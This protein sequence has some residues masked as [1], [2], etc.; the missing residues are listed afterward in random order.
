MSTLLLRLMGPMQS[1][2]TQYGFLVRLTD[3][4]PSFSGVVGLIA[5]AMGRSEREPIDDL[6]SGLQMGVRV[7][8]PG[9]LGVDFQTVMGGK[10]GRFDPKDTVLSYRHYIY[11][12]VFLVA[13]EGDA[14]LLAAVANALEWPAATLFLG[15][16]AC[17]PSAPV[18]IGP[19]RQ[20]DLE[21]ELTLTPWLGFGTPPGRLRVQL[22]AT[23]ASAG[24]LRH[25]YPLSFAPDHRAYASRPVRETWVPTP[26]PGGVT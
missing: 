13:L 11:D 20:H 7:D 22:P 19:G 14:G 23:T 26:M 4:E 24:F 18:L 1:W 5:A 8:R 15:R 12:A 25:D 3:M 9:Q 16:R 17:P 2:G 6:A 21:A 10:T